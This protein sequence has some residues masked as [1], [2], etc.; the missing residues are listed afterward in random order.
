MTVG[1]IA[2][3]VI[4]GTYVYVMTLCYLCDLYEQKKEKRRL[5]E[6][7]KRKEEL[8]RARTQAE[9]R[10]TQQMERRKQLAKARRE[11]GTRGTQHPS[12][13]PAGP[14]TAHAMR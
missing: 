13:G 8:R 5:A 6:A 3:S 14:H 12:S 10:R 7:E 11:K 1:V 2:L 9:M 4:V